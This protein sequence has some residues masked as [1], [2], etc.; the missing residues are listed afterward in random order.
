[1]SIEKT[2]TNIHE[3]NF[4]ALLQQNSKSFIHIITLLAGGYDLLE[5]IGEV[6]KRVLVHGVHIG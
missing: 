4:C 5:Q 2:S 6:V 3:D 1:M